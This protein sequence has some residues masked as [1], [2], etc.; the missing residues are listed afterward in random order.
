V[1]AEIDDSGVLGSGSLTVLE[2]Y[3]LSTESALLTADLSRFGFQPDGTSGDP[4]FEF[5]GNVTGGALM[6]DFGGSGTPVGMKLHAYGSFSGG[7]AVDYD[8]TDLS[9]VADIFPTPE[10][11]AL[12]L[13]VLAGL[14]CAWRRPGCRGG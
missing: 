2:N 12:V 10:P 14:V 11:G 1:D 8:S 9:N 3:G 4:T 5:E 13:V 7:F 6:M